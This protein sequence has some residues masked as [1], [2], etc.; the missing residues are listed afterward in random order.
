MDVSREDVLRCAR[1]TNL[2]LEED[3]I[4]PLREAMARL[5]ARARALDAFDLDSVDLEA[6]D[7]NAVLPRRADEERACL[8]LEEALGNAPATEADKF[9]VPKVL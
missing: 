5:L 9:K 7:A 4:E 1:L 3:E 8:S 6:M 2:R